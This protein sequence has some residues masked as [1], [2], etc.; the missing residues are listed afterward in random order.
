[1]L[2]CPKCGTLNVVSQTVCEHCQHS[3]SVSLEELQAI[4]EEL[5]QLKDQFEWKTLQIDLKITEIERRI[6]AEQ[7]RRKVAAVVAEADVP[8]A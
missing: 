4:R 1:M 8:Q 2:T 5:H 7:E 6:E 3:L